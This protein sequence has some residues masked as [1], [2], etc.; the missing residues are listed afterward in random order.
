[1]RGLIA[2]LR[3]FRKPALAL[4]AAAG[5]TVWGGG[6]GGLRAPTPGATPVP[7]RAGIASFTHVESAALTSGAAASGLQAPGG[8]REQTRVD[9]DGG[10]S[11]AASPSAPGLPGL[12]RPT[13][14]RLVVFFPAPASGLEAA[15]PRG[16]PSFPS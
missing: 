4:V 7:G 5:L 15:S 13:A 9:G 10:R 14:A 12:S 3:P 6:P 8:E 2:T 1:M 11:A 16:P